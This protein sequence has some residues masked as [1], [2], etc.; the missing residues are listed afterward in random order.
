MVLSGYLLAIVNVESIHLENVSTASYKPFNKSNELAPI[1]H[2]KKFHGFSRVLL[3]SYMPLT[4]KFGCAPQHA[5]QSDIL[6]K[7]HE[8]KVPGSFSSQQEPANPFAFC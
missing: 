1:M 4:L 5:T 6:V 8:T 2:A 7:V 3:V